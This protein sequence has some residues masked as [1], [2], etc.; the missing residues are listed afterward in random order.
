MI[1]RIKQIME[2]ENLTPSQ[3]ADEIDVQ[4]SSLSHVL[5]GRNKP[6]L[7]FVM[8]VKLC[9]SDINLEWLIF[10][11]GE[12]LESSTGVLSDTIQKEKTLFDADTPLNTIPESYD[13]PSVTNKKSNKFNKDITAENRIGIESSSEENNMVEKVILLLQDG[14]F[15]EYTN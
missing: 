5:S 13:D 15:R 11:N 12:M 4:R 8:K 14:T 1:D 6:S 3:F 2:M 10:G 7:D 9:F